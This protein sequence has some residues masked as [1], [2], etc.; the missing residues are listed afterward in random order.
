M[1]KHAFYRLERRLT[2]SA[3]NQQ[4]LKPIT[5]PPATSFK[6]NV[7]RSKTRKWAEAKNYSYDGDDWGGYDPYDEYGS[8]DDKGGAPAADARRNSF[9][10]GDETTAFSSGPAQQA[11]APAPL[12]H[13][14][15]TKPLPQA[16]PQPQDDRSIRR[17][18]SQ[19]A[20]VPPPL[21]THTSP[22]AVRERFPARKS[23]LPSSP[24]QASQLDQPMP[25]TAS[26]P[27]TAK[28]LPFIRPADIYKRMEEERTR[29]QERKNSVGQAPVEHEE[30]QASLQ[31][32]PEKPP[33]GTSLNASL[34]TVSRVASGFGSEFWNASELS[35]QLDDTDTPESVTTAVEATVPVEENSPE[36]TS[37]GL[38]AAVS[39][40][41]DRRVDDLS[42]PPTPIS[43]DNSQS[44]HGSDTAGIS[45]IMSR[46]PSAATAEAKARIADN[47]NMGAIAEES[48][49][50]G[51]PGS[52]PSSSQ[53]Q[54]V[55]RK[56]SPAHSRHVS[57][58]SF[59]NSPAR[60]PQL[61]YTK[62]LSTPMSAESTSL[63]D[64]EAASPT[65]SP[66]RGHP[67]TSVRVIAPSADYSRRESDIVAE[68]SS[69][70]PSD[71]A[72]AAKSA[73]AQF[74]QTHTERTESPAV[75]SPVDRSPSPAS[76]RGSPGPSRVRDLA[77]KYNELHTLS[78]SSS[79]M[80][81]NSKNSDTMSLKRSGT[82]ESN[83]SENGD[84]IVDG[85][86]VESIEQASPARPEPDRGFS[87]RPHLPGEWVSYVGTPSSEAP[88]AQEATRGREETN[89]THP[90]METPRQAVFPS[91][92]DFDP[93]PATV[94]QPLAHRN[95]EP[96]ESSP[97]DAVRAAGDALGA[98]LLSTFGQNHGTKD[99]AQ[100]EP[101][102]PEKDLAK[103]D[104]VGPRP[105]VGDV[106]L[107]PLMV[108]RMASSVASSVAPTPLPKDT[109]EGLNLQRASGY[110]P[111]PPLRV[112]S[113]A[114]SP[115]S[116]YS[117]ADLESDRLRREIERSLTPQFHSEDQQT[118]DQDALDAPGHLHEVQKAEGFSVTD[119]QPL[120]EPPVV[121]EEPKE[122]PSALPS[123]NAT[124]AANPGLLGKRFSFEKDQ[125]NSGLWGEV[126]EETKRASYERPRSSVGLHVVNTNVSSSSS[127]GA[128]SIK[129]IPA[130]ALNES[131]AAPRESATSP[132]SPVTSPDVPAVSTEEDR[133]NTVSAPA[134]HFPTEVDRSMDEQPLPTPPAEADTT[135][136][137]RA[138]TS[139]ARI[140]PFREILALKSVHERIDTYNSTRDQF[141]SMDTGLSNWLSSTL[142]SH[143][144]H[145][146]VVTDAMNKP[147]TSNAVGSIR[148]KHQ[149][150]NI[151]KMARKGLGGVSSREPSGTHATDSS[152]TAS[153]VERQNSQG[154]SVSAQHGGVEKMQTKG[155][156]LLHS[157]G[158][159][160]GKA[161]VGAKGLFARAKG[162][163]REG[164]SEKV[165]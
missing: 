145:A 57:A 52:R 136:A 130:E 143:P 149:P 94:K 157:A 4:L 63:Q 95:I 165:D 150:S 39:Q 27:S 74:L 79:A 69:S 98:A 2:Y 67:I 55:V 106:Y 70:S 87:F 21:K 28:P 90:D 58:E 45:P 100:P 92:E 153:S 89:T 82:F 116:E 93:A 6:T 121:I 154:R 118:R 88:V 86:V 10:T 146:H 22:Q 68:A 132:L 17:D 127:S 56:A 139:A 107:R 83:H 26:T 151:M 147:A 128:S 65:A 14:T 33:A 31:A 50:P 13:T 133:G 40:A 11:V 48:S 7:N 96:K 24:A 103:Q 75:T 76:H 137:P 34:P 84:A 114:I 37:A 119:N 53:Q 85:N 123:A 160:G 1:C 49:L 32:T 162:R 30:G 15:S 105:S 29:E 73:R 18:F 41:F 104:Q 35:K 117:P 38:H 64:E 152:Q 156:D 36:D 25:D 66:Y 60:T 12:A 125:A 115:A 164:G 9:E 138:S 72:E 77:G 122:A 155:K 144:E 126:G 44:G 20:H 124:Q 135:A 148:Y 80:S 43:R 47:R 59:S 120:V 78:R 142:S 3:S 62:R 46:V 129:E 113:D 16:Q 81:F 111:P 42:V 109:P 54:S 141:A 61:E 159:L 91:T 97:V 140:P 99:F 5:Q 110:F 161:T 134:V 112:N 19:I 131:T 8:Y 101:Q 108:D 158:M 23:S 102:S 163:L 71:T 51:S